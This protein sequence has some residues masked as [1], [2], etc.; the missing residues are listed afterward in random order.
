MRRLV[1]DFDPQTL[2][3]KLSAESH[4]S[5]DTV[6]SYASVTSCSPISTHYFER[7]PTKETAMTAEETSAK[8][9]A[10]TVQSVNSTDGFHTT[11]MDDFVQNPSILFLISVMRYLSSAMPFSASTLETQY[12][13][14]IMLA[15]SVSF[16]IL[17]I[18]SPVASPAF[19]DSPLSSFRR[20]WSNFR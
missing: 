12:G 8:S 15:S 6:F 11:F 3:Q 4:C 16:S 10:A 5:I 18:A 17:A 20:S 9:E 14:S 7:Q 19:N 13:S 1:N 2:A